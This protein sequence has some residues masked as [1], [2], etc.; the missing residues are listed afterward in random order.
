MINKYK[1]CLLGL[2]IGDALGASVEFTS[3]AEI[4]N[5]YGKDGIQDFDKWGGFE[6]G[7]YT[8]DTQMA[9]ATVSGCIK[10]ITLLL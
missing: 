4:K 8:D 5:K 2:A 10:A 9:M 3:L 1:G 7:S 6:A